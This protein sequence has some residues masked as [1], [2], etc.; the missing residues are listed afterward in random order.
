M[1]D[2]SDIEWTDATWNPV[3]GCDKISPGCKHCYAETFA[4]RFRGVKGHA[5]EQGFDLRTVPEA[6]Q[7]PLRWKR[8]RRIFVNSMSDLFH[9]DVP[10]SFIDEVIATMLLAHWHTYQVLTKRAERMAQHLS[11]PGLYERVLAIVN[12]I[13]DGATGALRAHLYSVGVSN[14]MTFPAPW[15]WWGV[16]VED[17]ARADER[18]PHLLRT[19]A[20]VRFLSCEPLLER[21]ELRRWINDPCNCMVPTMEGAGQHAPKCRTFQEPWGIDWIIVGGESGPGARPMHPEWA[22][23][24]RDQCIAA[25]VPFFF[26][27]W[28]A[29][30]EIEYDR[31]SPPGARDGERYLNLAGG[32]GFHGESVVRLRVGRKQNNGRLL[33]GREWNEFPSV[34]P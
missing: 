32:H 11:D 4:E 19:P 2:K 10:S 31:E 3:R 26:K 22:R 24:L 12:R 17:Q 20:A 14:P 9:K 7:L 6:L 23:S 30:L 29:W 1:G 34:R 18:I 13:R 8:A 5:Y 27:Q 16:S 15:I 25:R 28:G 33:N 21:V